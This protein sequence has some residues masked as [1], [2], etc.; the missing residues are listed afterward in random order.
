MADNTTLNTGSGGDVIR[1]KDRTGVKTNVGVIDQQAS[2]AESLVDSVTNPLLVASAAPAATTGNLTGTGQTVSV[3]CSKYSVAGFMISGTYVGGV[4]I[5][6]SLDGGTTWQAMYAVRTDINAVEAVT[7]SLT[8]TTRMWEADCGAL[9]NVQIRCSA[10]TSGT[11]AGRVTLSAAGAPPALVAL[12]GVAEITG[13]HG[14]NGNTTTLALDGGYTAVMFS[15]TGTSTQTIQFEQSPD[16]TNWMALSVTTLLATSTITNITST[17]STQAWQGNIL[18]G[19]KAVRLRTSAYTSGS[20]TSII[21]AT[22]AGGT[23]WVMGGQVS[24]S[25]AAT[26]GTSVTPGTS[27]AHLGKAE[28]ATAASGDTGVAILGVRKDAPASG[29]SADGDYATINVDN[30]GRLWAHAVPDLITLQVSSAGLT[31]ATTAYV[32]G[33]QLGSEI[34]VASAA[35]YSGGSGQI[36][37]VNLI[38]Y[39]KVVGAVDIF[40]FNAASTPAADNA[41]NSWADQ[42]GLM[43]VI[44]LPSPLASANQSVATV[45]NV[46]LGYVC[47][48]SSL[49]LNLVTRSG[50][51][52][53]GA[54][55]DLKLSITLQR[56]L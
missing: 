7:P 51:T 14:A 17:S 52:W 42:T 11:I 5:E 20:A 33:D 48:A 15:T 13:S 22:T 38:D 49:F 18:P 36:L 6:G 53:F 34:T 4:T 37:S 44:N 50:H 55:T 32:A 47:A 31:T 23:K 2:G 28:D 45:T 10:Y 19:A 35:L 12:P 26:I 16:G 54:A 3:D 46:G 30:Y 1:N 24:V 39:A 29:V 9:T 43:G 40:V 25:N 8:N 56:G 21:R 27:A 41:A